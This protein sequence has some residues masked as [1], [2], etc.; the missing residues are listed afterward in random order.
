MKKS[1]LNLAILFALGAIACNSAVAA[2]PGGGGGT[3]GGEKGSTL[4][5]LVVLYRDASGLPILTADKCQQPLAAP[6]VVVPNCPQTTT[7]SDGDSCILPVDPAT[8]AVDPAF[9]IYLQEVDFGRISVSRSPADVIAQQLNEVLVTLS[10]SSCDLTLDPAGRLVFFAPDTDDSDGDDDTT[11]LISSEIDSP[12]QNLAIYKELMIKGVLGVPAIALPS[13]FTGYNYLDT[14]A[15]GLGAAADK[16]GKISV[17]LIVYLNQIL[18]LSNKDSTTVLPKTCVTVREEV[19]GAVQDVEKCFL[20]YGAYGYTRA[21]TYG[22]LPYP[23][24]IPDGAAVPGTIE[25]LAEYPLDPPLPFPVFAIQQGPINDVVFGGLPG[26]TGGN[27]GGF[28]QAGDDAREV[29]DFIHNHPVLE[30]YGTP[31][32]CTGTPPTPTPAFD[33]AMSALQMPIRMVVNSE[34]EGTVSVTNNGPNSASGQ[35]KLDGT[36]SRGFDLNQS[37][38]FTDLASGQSQ[39]WTVI[40]TAPSYA[41]TIDWTA[42]VVAPGD[43]LSTNNTLTATTQVF[44]RGGSPGRNDGDR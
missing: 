36:D 12:L 28:A 9:A 8:C 21:Q 10:T 17:D 22:N 2:G 33:V 13:P 20:N 18:G 15:K 6:G 16:G 44:G 11:E 14:A 32:P 41:T 37:F 40:F 5:D 3:G 27:I 23:P 39:S 4:G 29:V 34:R 7:T 31:V 43:V 25:Y 38:D 42:T 30:G 26:F 24:Y 1:K 35:V 19:K